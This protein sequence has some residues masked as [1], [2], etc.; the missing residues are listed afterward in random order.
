[1]CEVLFLTATTATATEKK[2]IVFMKNFSEKIRKPQKECRTF[3][4]V[5]QWEK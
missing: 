4:I 3:A 2:K 5:N 1:M